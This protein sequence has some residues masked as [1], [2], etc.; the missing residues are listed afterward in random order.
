MIAMPKTSFIALSCIEC[1]KAAPSPCCQ[2]TP[3]PSKMKM[4]SWKGIAE[5]PHIRLNAGAQS[6]CRV[7]FHT[8][9]QTEAVPCG[10]PDDD[11]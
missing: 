2:T 5:K 8:G 7:G 9:A 3:D 10:Q 6:Q 1:R 4:K 11:S